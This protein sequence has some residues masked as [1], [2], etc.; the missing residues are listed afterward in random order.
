MKN[1][2]SQIKKTA[3]DKKPDSNEKVLFRAGGTN[4]VTKS[5]ASNSITTIKKLTIEQAK[6]LT[7]DIITCL[8]KHNKEQ[9]TILAEAQ[10]TD[11]EFI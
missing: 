11:L 9:R 4:N 1:N 7:K 10:L 5:E 2:I 3:V 8:S 6:S